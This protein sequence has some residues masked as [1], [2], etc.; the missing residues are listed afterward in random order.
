MEERKRRFKPEERKAQ[1][2]EVTKQLI[3][4]KG[5]AWASLDRISKSLNITQ[6][7]LYYHFKN[8]QEIIAETLKIVM[9]EMLEPLAW[10]TDDVIAYL[11]E[12]ARVI[13]E[14]TI[15]NP[16]QARLIIELISAPLLED[17][18]EEVRMRLSDMHN[19]FE[20]IIKKGVQ[21]GIF[22]KDTNT[23]Q[24]AW[25]IM[26]LQLAA[27]VGSMTQVPNFV[28][29]EEGLNSLDRILDSIKNKKKRSSSIKP[30]V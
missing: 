12:S 23:K 20:S 16:K 27:T 14:R 8:R 22:R 21:Q 28:T 4:E 6:N 25:E 5:L 19:L 10:E 11:H 26:S 30:K 24:I 1:I 15:E 13:Y 9:A 2:I 18:F 3:L 17:M 7:T 29:I